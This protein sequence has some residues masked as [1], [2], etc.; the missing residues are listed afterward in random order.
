MRGDVEISTPLFILRPTCPPWETHACRSTCQFMSSR[1]QDE[2]QPKCQ[3]LEIGTSPF[4]VA[5]YHYP[6]SP[7]QSNIHASL[8]KPQMERSARIAFPFRAY[9]ECRSTFILWTHEL[10]VNGARCNHRPAVEITR[11]VTIDVKTGEI[12]IP[13]GPRFVPPSFPE[14]M[15]AGSRPM[16]QLAPQGKTLAGCPLG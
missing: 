3:L 4:E 16:E 14:G 15:V 8:R 7:F 1:P 2:P 12:E 6:L 5:K 9:F 13:D 10:K 11:Y